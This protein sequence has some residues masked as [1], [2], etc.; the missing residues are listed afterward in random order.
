MRTVP[1]QR[2]DIA[3]RVLPDCC[4]DDAL[5]LLW[6]TIYVPCVILIERED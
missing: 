4:D 3:S 6:R 2:I 1:R 5:H